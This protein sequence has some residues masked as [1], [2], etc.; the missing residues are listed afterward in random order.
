MLLIIGAGN[1][2]KSIAYMCL[3]RGIS[4]KMGV[5]SIDKVI[6]SDPGLG[7]HLRPFDFENQDTFAPAL[8][9][10]NH[11][12]FI[13]AHPEPDQSVQS[14]LEACNRAD[15]KH[16]T[17]SSGRTTGD[18]VGKPL[19]RVEKLVENAGLPYT[20]LRPGWFMQNF[21]TWIGATISSERLFFLPAAESRTAFVDVRDIADMALA[22]FNHAGMIDKVI[23]VTSEEVLDHYMVAEKLSAHLGIQVGYQPLSEKDYV[24]KM[25]SLGWQPSAAQHVV[26]LYAIVKTGKEEEISPSVREFLGRSP[27][28]FDTFLR[29]HPAELSRL[30]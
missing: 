19:N 8:D 13:A 9:S 10:A 29:H 3:S 5:R 1:I 21:V 23:D 30:V 11:I 24:Q 25:L 16:V 6:H 7:D 28:D 26:D 2:G 4:F 22:S 20:I 18:I 17:F 12:F 15:A 14:F 27:Y